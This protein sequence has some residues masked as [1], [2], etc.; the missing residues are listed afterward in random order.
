MKCWLDMSAVSEDIRIWGLPL[1]ERLVKQIRSFGILDFV[2]FVSEKSKI[3]RPE[4]NGVSIVMV[5]G[6]IH[7]Q[8]LH[9]QKL[10]GSDPWLI[11]LGHVVFDPRIVKK[12]LEEKSTAVFYNERRLPVMATFYDSRHDRI[13]ELWSGLANGIIEYDSTSIPSY[14]PAHRMSATVFA[15]EIRNSEDAR[16]AEDRLFEISVKGVM[17]ILY[18]Y[19][20]TNI[21]KF[22]IKVF[23]N[24]RLSP[25]QITI[26]YL[27]VAAASF[28][29][30]LSGHFS[31]GLILSFVTMVMDAWDGILARLTFQ[32][33]KLG[34]QLDKVS[35]SI[36]HPLWYFAMAYPLASA[37]LVSMPILNAV[38][39]T[40][41]FFIMKP[42]TI[43]YNRKYGRS[44]YDI[45]NFDRKFR[46]FTG[47]RWNMNMIILGFAQALDK[48]EE[49]FYAITIYG[50]VSVFYWCV[51]YFGPK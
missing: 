3:R 4:V 31:A 12:L 39:L 9:F 20:Y 33:S 19:V 43:S 15:L 5:E 46:L 29:C 2:L 30:F 22:L 10:A 51:R 34:H 17:D 6:D 21:V 35:H 49:G 38:A 14:I 26:T 47:T 50:M 7:D 32:S 27:F 13:S 8:D 11:A 16:L 44:I 41:L 36:Y 23:S 24:T 42:I 40:I 28:L 1:A 48:F 18:T 25:N 37:N 45:T